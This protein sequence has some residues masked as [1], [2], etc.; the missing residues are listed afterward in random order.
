M[1]FKHL[2]M[3]QTSFNGLS[4]TKGT[5]IDITAQFN[6]VCRSM[7]FKVF[8]E[9]KD[10]VAENW[11]GSHGQAVYIPSYNRTKDYEIEVQFLYVGTHSTM[12]SHIGNFVKYINGHIGVGAADPVGARLAIYD[13]YTQTG[14][15]DVRVKNVDFGGWYDNADFDT[16]A[17]ADFKVKFQVYDPVTDVTP[18]FTQQG[19]LSD[20]TWT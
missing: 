14:R 13:E 17:I 4:Y 1:A 9:T 19:A 15:K 7:P 5:A 12:R 8:P 2:Y 6:V 3:Q 18:T 11:I 20:L 16:D 10:V